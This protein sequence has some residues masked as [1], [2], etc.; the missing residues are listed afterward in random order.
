VRSGSKVGSKYKAL[1]A[2][3]NTAFA[4][5]LRGALEAEVPAGANC[6]Y[7]IVIDGLSLDAVERATAAGI[8]AIRERPG[9]VAIGA[10]NYGGK[11]GPHH[12][13]LLD[14]LERHPCP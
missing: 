6:S 8:H 11:L 3:S 1:R 9:V 13:R 4:P 12:I 10:G 7:E 2:S 14:V 5:S